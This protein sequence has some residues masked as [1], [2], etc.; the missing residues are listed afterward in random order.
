MIVAAD[1]PDR[2]AFLTAGLNQIDQGIAVFDA[3]LRLVLW[4]ARFLDLMDLPET[5]V[6]AGLPF[7]DLVRYLA[8][9]G[10]YGDRID[11]EAVV[12]ARVRTARD[13]PRFYTERTT[14]DRR[15]IAVQTSPLPE[16][17]FVTVYTDVSDRSVTDNFTP[18]RSDLLEARVN[19]RTLELRLL[20][21]ELQRRIRQTQETS[22][23]LAK[24]EQRLRLITDNVPAAIAYLDDAMMVTYANRRYV[25]LFPRHQGA[26]IGKRLPDLVPGPVFATM[27][28]DMALALTGQS[29]TFELTLPRRAGPPLMTRN[30][31]VPEIADGTVRGM[32]VLSLD[33]TEEKRAEE[34]LRQAQKM[35]AVGQL[36]GGLAHDFNN[37][38]TVVLG[39]LA[40]LRDRIP[41]DLF[42]E[43][44]EPALRA[45]TRGTGLT[46]RL[47]AFARQQPLEPVPVDVPA[48]IAGVSQLLRRSL[49]G[50]IILN[51]SG[52]A[53]EGYPA[54]V[55]PHRLEDA[56]VNMAINARDAMPEGGMLTLATAF[57][58]VKQGPAG[59]T[60]AP[61]DYVRLTVSDTGSGMN[62][63]TAAHA[64]EPF[65]TTK[66]FGRGS[67]LGLSMVYGFVKQSGGAIVLNSAPGRGT[68]VE[69]FLPRARG[70][71]VPL[72]EPPVEA[73][74]APQGSGELVLLVEDDDDVRQIIRRQLVELGYG[75]LEA[76]A[77]TEALALMAA[78]ADIRIVVSDI[79]MPG[80]VDGRALAERA[81]RDRPELHV[82]LVSGYSGPD[83]DTRP[84]A[85]QTPILRK[86]FGVAD[87]A[88]A[89]RA[90]RPEQ[91]GTTG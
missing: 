12:E 65:F 33:V 69:I 73:S 81:R 85:G 49:P 67:G 5:L 59:E 21:D 80:G 6:D 53:G 37:L 28:H 36:A 56:I 76:R 89:L 19:R 64:F 74:P 34:A 52:D 61:G 24:S 77:G 38:L 23:A 1:E 8:V 10:E 82:V 2:T 70:M 3:G 29:R 46:R 4:N 62:A 31:L 43:Y 15:T 42:A 72:A 32:F 35:S 17:G 88:A 9:Q 90:G 7:G 45:A 16:G 68:S 13:R 41:G 91:T 86:P 60:L 79:V 55:D 50:N 63:E 48:L 25:G 20:A 30:V 83:D 84:A 39:N 11:V 71:A 75:V 22:S 44:V 66:P 40:G 26:V 54:L 47:L 51:C 87:L 78:V 27:A 18:E 14:F 58:T 57:R